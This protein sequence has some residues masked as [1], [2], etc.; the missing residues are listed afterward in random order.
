MGYKEKRNIFLAR[1]MVGGGIETEVKK[2]NKAK[3]QLNEDT[4]IR[5]E[6]QAYISQKVKEGKSKEEI[7]KR[8]NFT[9]GASKYLSYRKYFERWTDNVMKKAIQQEE[10]DD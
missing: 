7:L 9:F 3:K 10:R 5:K 2:I 4:K 8:L 1:N 6:I